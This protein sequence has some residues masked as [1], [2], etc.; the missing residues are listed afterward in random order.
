MRA[1]LLVVI[2]ACGS[3]KGHPESVRNRAAPP[4]KPACTDERMAGIE[5]ELRARWKTTG[6]SIVRCTPGLF[7]TPGF[8]IGLDKDVEHRV[9]VVGT[10]GEEIIAF[11]SE[12]PRTLTSVTDCA[13]VD[14][15]GDGIDEIV[16]TWREVAHGR[17]GSSSW[18]EIRRLDGAALATIRG[19]HTSVSHP[20]L[21][22]CSAE[23][24]LAGQTIVITVESTS[25]IPPSDCL[26]PGTHT[27]A[28]D[29][30]AIVE[31][32]AKRISRR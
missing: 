13:T 16:E 19:P 11:E 15:D 7:P 29:R 25:G 2:A 21:G 30:D 9:G 8:F 20:D 3:A 24:R 4:P 28:L 32:G 6:V 12:D 27:F 5:N 14:L 22:G 10:G 23:V 31:L 18:L 1:L 26:S 17:V